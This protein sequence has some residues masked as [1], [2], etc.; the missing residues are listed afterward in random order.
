[1]QKVLG[2]QNGFFGGTYFCTLYFPA[3]MIGKKIIVE[4]RNA[5]SASA[6]YIND[7]EIMRFGSPSLT[8][9]FSKPGYNS[10][11][12]EVIVSDRVMFLTVHFSN[13]EFKA[14]G[15]LSSPIIG[16]SKVIEAK[17]HKR[18]ILNIFLMGSI[19]VMFF[20]HI[21]IFAMRRKEY[22]SLWFSIIS[23]IVIIRTLLTESYG[24][25]FI[26]N[27]YSLLVDIECSTFFMIIPAFII[28][29]Y[30]FA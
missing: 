21:L 23:F 17:N 20:Y 22:S 11:N 10:G 16:F 6:F 24:Y 13:R 15:F 25:L 19:A 2:T 29:L 8:A 27:Y 1:M 4:Q 18:S 28:F 5:N 14:G 12:A 7:K 26:R 9:E 30:Y 3:D